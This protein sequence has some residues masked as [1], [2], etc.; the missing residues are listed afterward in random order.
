MTKKPILERLK[1]GPV[2]GDGGYLLELERRGYVRAGP[3]TPEVCVEHPEALR[4]LH[5][6]FLRAGS[7]VL[8]TCTFYAS[9]EKLRSAGLAAQVEQ[10]NRS[11]VRIAREVAGDN[12]LVAGNLSLTWQYNPDDRSSNHRVLELFR[13]QVALQKEEGVDFFIAETFHYLGE[14]LL[15]LKAIKEAGFPAMLTFNFKEPPVS[16]DGHS[17]AA[18][19]RILEDSGADIVGTNCGREPKRM[20]PLAE[21]MR[22]AVRC[23]VAAQPAGFHSTDAIPYFMGLPAFP[24]ELDPLQLTRLEMADFVRRARDLGINY[25]GACCGVTAAHIRSMAE[26]LGRTPEASAK[27]PDLDIHP[28]LGPESRG[29]ATR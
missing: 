18:C 28:I 12:A 22:K 4:Q 8:Q 29:A 26:A 14:A 9:Q 21:E 20:L 13:Q 25:I 2:L 1:E 7:E 10:I 17:P 6:E 5:R 15:A 11:A 23:Y 3:Y 27:S 24:L 19:A 16:R